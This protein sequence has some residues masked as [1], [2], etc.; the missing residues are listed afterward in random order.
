M[1]VGSAANV[2]GQMSFLLIPD[3]SADSIG[4]YSAVDGSLIN[5][6]FIVDANSAETYDFTTPK[7][8]LQVGNEIWVTDQVADAVYVFD[9]NGNYLSKI[10]QDA[11]GNSTGEF[12]NIRGL[13]FDGTTVFVSNSGTNGGAPGDAIITIN[14]ATRSVTGNFQVVDAATGDVTDPFDV[15]FYNGNLLISDIAGGTNGEGVDLIATDGTYLQR[16]VS[17]DGIDGID[18]PQQLSG[19]FS[20]SNFLA[21]GFSPPDG[22]YEFASDGSQVNFF[23]DTAGR[24]VFEL[25]NGTYLYTSGAGTFV[26]DPTTGAFFSVGTGSQYISRFTVIPEPTS[27]GLILTAAVAVMLRRR[28]SC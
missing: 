23:A 10:G 14:A 19:K 28:R 6:N 13:G 27:A 18:F 2:H 12:D 17:S 9:S 15:E 7:E 22:L 21:A 3:S 11:M 16:L 20:D 1:A 5:A 26:L 25:G 8:A 24:G 4:Q